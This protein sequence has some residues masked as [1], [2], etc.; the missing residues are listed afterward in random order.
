MLDIGNQWSFVD[1]NTVPFIVTE[2]DPVSQT[3]PPLALDSQ[4]AQVVPQLGE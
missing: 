4:D 2:T 3:E 1:A